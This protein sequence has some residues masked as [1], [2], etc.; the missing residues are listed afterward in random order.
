MRQKVAGTTDRRPKAVNDVMKT[1]VNNPCCLCGSAE[2]RLLFARTFSGPLNPGPFAIRRC[3]G[4]GLL[5]NSP[6]LHAHGIR[7]LYN[8]QYCFFQREDEPEFERIVNMYQRT[9]AE[10][11]RQ[12]QPGRM[13]EIGSAK[14]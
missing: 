6:R 14:G 5:F 3:S 4:C 10:M 7:S 1:E 13:L 2:S 9:I 12:M 8:D 11:G